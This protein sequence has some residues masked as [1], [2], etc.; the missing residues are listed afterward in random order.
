MKRYHD[1]DSND[2]VVTLI[3]FSICLTF[4]LAFMCGMLWALEKEY[5]LGITGRSSES[6]LIERENKGEE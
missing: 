3:G 2:I 5:E 6:L 4:G 1:I